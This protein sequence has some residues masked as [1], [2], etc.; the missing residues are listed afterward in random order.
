MDF[1]KNKKI[2]IT[3]GSGFV[4][5][6]LLKR[7]SKYDCQLKATI[8]KSE[9]QIKNKKIQYIKT[10]LT[11]SENCQKITKDIDLI[12]MCAANTSGA[13][14]IQ[15]NPLAHL[16]PNILMNLSLLESAYIN[17]VTK[18]LF[19]SSN[20]V[21]PVTDYP[22]KEDDVTND[23]YHKYFIVAW[24]KRFTEIV[25]E[26]Y[27]KKI[28]NGMSVVVVRPANLYGSYDDFEWETSH[29]IPALIRKVIERHDPIEVWGDGNELKEF[30]YIDDFIDGLLL[31]MEKISSSD[32]I[33]LSMNEPITVREII[34]TL[35][36]LDNYENAKIIYDTSKPTMIPKR[37]IDN[38]LAKKMIGFE[39]KINIKE[40]LMKTINWYRESK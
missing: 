6:N 2:L 1:F 23:F 3:G 28:K 16:T 24:M 9:P 7:L 37:L 13:A 27:S 35:V 26:M 31:A 4:G 11:S 34:D 32:P 17:N 19:I 10:D 40:G 36:R 33:N 8:H 39:P 14:V 21:Y 5:T 18:V 38:T 15:N 22:V 25:S 30:L 29:V 20:T 12:F